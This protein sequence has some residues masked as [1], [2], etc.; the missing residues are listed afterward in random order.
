MQTVNMS[1]EVFVYHGV[2]HF[3]VL[4]G[5]GSTIG[6]LK[7]AITESEG[8][9]GFKPY[10]EVFPADAGTRTK[11]VGSA[12][13]DVEARITDALP[14]SPRRVWVEPIETPAV[15]TSSAVPGTSR[16]VH[17]QCLGVVQ[18]RVMDMGVDGQAVAIWWSVR[19]GEF[20]RV[21][22]FG[23]SR[24]RA[25]HA[26]TSLLSL[27]DIFPLQVSLFPNKALQQV[28]SRRN[29]ARSATTIRGTRR[30]FLRGCK[31]RSGRFALT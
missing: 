23:A 8:I 3:S 5:E 28:R 7:R 29:D 12:A 17:M 26:R 24:G 4:V 18:T 16:Q 27:V 20:C 13:L 19:R 21:S 25:S 1:I 30:G 11:V 10:W 14:T 31:G 15:G 2:Y 9:P 22:A 6:S